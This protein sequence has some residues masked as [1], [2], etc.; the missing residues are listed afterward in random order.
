[1]PV[2]LTREGFEKLK[3]D[4]SYLRTVKRKEIVKALS[5]AR[6][7]GDLSE[8]AEYDA[9]KEAQAQ[10]EL[11]IAELET[12][13]SDVRIIDEERMEKDKAYIG[14]ILTLK[15]LDKKTTLRYMIVSKE[16]ASLSAGKISVESPVG[17]AL[18]GRKP[19]DVVEITIPA[20]KLRYQIE[21]L[22]RPT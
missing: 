22:E 4:L 5:E 1:M 8:N 10:L 16:E 9:A 13:L 18:L 6:A 21:K 2:H 20:G 17:R 3:E 14:A 15:D 11:R 19:G 12:K 7:H